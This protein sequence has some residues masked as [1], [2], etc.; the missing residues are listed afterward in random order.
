MLV[1]LLLFLLGCSSP[2][3]EILITDSPSSHSNLYD[4]LSSVRDERRYV[5]LDHKT[6]LK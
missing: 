5:T 4:F 2:R 1:K 3:N 6:S